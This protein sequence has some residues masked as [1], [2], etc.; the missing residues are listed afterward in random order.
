MK[1]WLLVFL[2]LVLAACG[3]EDTKEDNNPGQNAFTENE[4]KD[5]AMDVLKEFWH[6]Y[7]DIGTSSSPEEKREQLLPFMTDEMYTKTFDGKG[8]EKPGFPA[9]PFNAI[10]GKVLE[11]SPDS[12]TIAHILPASAEGESAIKQTTFFEKQ[13]ERF[14]VSDFK[15][16]R[17]KLSLTQEQAEAFLAEQGYELTFIKKGSFD[18]LDT[19]I[20]EAYF[21]QDPKEERIQMVINKENGYFTWFVK[22]KDTGV[23]DEK[24]AL[25]LEDIRDQYSHLFTHQLSEIDVS[26]LSAEQQ[27]IYN[28]YIIQPIEQAIDIDFDPALTDEERFSKTTE[29]L[30][31]TVAGLLAE[32]KR[33][34]NE[35]AFTTLEANHEIWL[36]NRQKYANAMATVSGSY[37]EADFYAAYKEVT[38]DYL[39]RL[40]YEYLYS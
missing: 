23:D 7:N 28:T 32:I 25:K 24:E 39:A 37:Q 13:E 21:F 34:A 18:E 31:Q 26:K 30:D 15:K 19:P 33:T 11:I 14:V 12:F 9:S 5:I 10:E 16:E 2:L 36:A 29:L 20:D 4:A 40:F 8:K 6:V 35:K 27:R 38:E 22:Y 17:T 1:K 3:A